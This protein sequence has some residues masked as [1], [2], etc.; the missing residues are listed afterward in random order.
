[1]FV[2]EVSNTVYKY[3]RL[4]PRGLIVVATPLDFDFPTKFCW[5]IIHG[6]VFEVKESNGHS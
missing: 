6:Y 5:E 2:D 1:M 3:K 4:Q